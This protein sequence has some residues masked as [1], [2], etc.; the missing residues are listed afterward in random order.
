MYAVA[1]GVPPRGT[2]AAG[3]V[4]PAKQTTLTTGSLSLSTP[5]VPTPMIPGATPKSKNKKRKAGSISSTATEQSDKSTMSFFQSKNPGQKYKHKP[6]IRLSDDK[7]KVV[8]LLGAPS[9]TENVLSVSSSEI[10]KAAG[11]TKY[12]VAAL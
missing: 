7:K 3:T 9:D 8:M 11:N 10:L 2:P 12:C 1:D 4:T 6:F 5:V